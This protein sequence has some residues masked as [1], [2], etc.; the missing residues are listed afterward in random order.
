MAKQ[1]FEMGTSIDI[2]V[3][4]TDPNAGGIDLDPAGLSLVIRA[5]DGTVS[6]LEIGDLTRE[7]AGHYIYVLGTP[8]EGT[9]NWRWHANT[10]TKAI[11]LTGT[12]D[13]RRDVDFE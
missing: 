6:T 7:S 8:Q 2:R 3:H 1:T 4:F 5:P 12:L 10:P 9:Y 13:S 11:V